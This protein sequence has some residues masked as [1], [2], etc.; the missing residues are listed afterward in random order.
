M[1]EVTGDN[2]TYLTYYVACRWNRN[3]ELPAKMQGFDSLK[4]SVFYYLERGI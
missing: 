1:W 2:Y 4:K 3:K